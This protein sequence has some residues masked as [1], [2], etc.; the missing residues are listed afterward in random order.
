MILFVWTSLIKDDLFEILEVQN[1]T[2]NVDD[3]IPKVDLI[4]KCAVNETKDETSD[5]ECQN[6]VKRGRIAKIV[7]DRGFGFIDSESDNSIFFHFKQLKFLKKDLKIDQLVT[8]DIQE[9][10]NNGK[11]HA[12]NINLSSSEIP[13]EPKINSPKVIENSQKDSNSAEE[14]DI[15]KALKE[16]QDKHE[17]IVFNS[18]AFECLVCFA[19]KLGKDCLQFK[20][21]L[22]VFCQDCMKSYFD[23]K[24]GEGEMSSLTCPQ[25]KCTA[26]ALPTQV[27]ALVSEKKFQLYEQ[28]LLSTTLESMADIVLCPRAHCQ[29]PT[30]IDREENMGQCPKCTF[31]F[32]IYCKASFHG[33]APCRY[34]VLLCGCG[35]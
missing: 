15:I 34:V 11:T 26:Q 27:K 5:V 24:I 28:V 32:C 18:E 6:V 12:V 2:L 8:F 31:V 23:V 17:Q 10:P 13:E 20:P 29:C 14:P 30:I 33:V 22:H 16:F 3:L 9:N 19:D 1:N 35:V 25:D 7:Q 4:P 21:C